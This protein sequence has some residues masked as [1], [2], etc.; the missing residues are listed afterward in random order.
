MAKKLSH[1]DSRAIDMLLDRS[2]SASVMMSA[3]SNVGSSTVKNGKM[4]M[5]NHLRAADRVLRTLSQMPAAE[6]SADLVKRTLARID[7]S[8]VVAPALLSEPQRYVDNRPH[9]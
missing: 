1:E 8:T 2:G 9:A 4:N 5:K 3:V 7:E 6:P